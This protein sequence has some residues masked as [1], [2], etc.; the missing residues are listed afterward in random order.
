MD[1]GE[2]ILTIHYHNGCDICEIAKNS[3]IKK[4]AVKIEENDS[5]KNTLF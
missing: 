3:L 2:V 5:D 1:S 4:Q